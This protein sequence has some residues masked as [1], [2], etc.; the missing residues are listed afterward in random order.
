ME[1]LD[2]RIDEILAQGKKITPMD[3]VLLARHPKRPKIQQYIDTL[4]TEF[5]E[6][7]FVS[8]PETSSLDCSR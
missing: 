1:E 3:K 4:F 5:F 8:P 6:A 7:P 2:I